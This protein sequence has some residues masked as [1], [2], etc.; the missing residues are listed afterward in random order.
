MAHPTARQL[1]SNLNH[2]Y[3]ACEQTDYR[4]EMQGAGYSEGEAEK[5]QGKINQVLSQLEDIMPGLQAEL[6]EK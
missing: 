4:D 6:N 1:F 2:L 3:N 5:L